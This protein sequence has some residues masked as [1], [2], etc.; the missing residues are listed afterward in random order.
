M[1]KPEP[2]LCAKNNKKITS[3]V[4]ALREVESLKANLAESKADLAAM[5]QEVKEARAEAKEV[6]AARAQAQPK[7]KAE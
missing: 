7:T 5:R 4:E 6:R 3:G 2:D 1:Q